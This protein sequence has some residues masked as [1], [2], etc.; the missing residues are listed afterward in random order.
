MNPPLLP[1]LDRS[2][3]LVGLMGAGKSSVGK[4][5]AQRL[6]LPFVDADAEIEAAA[7]CTIEA[8]FE[9]FGEAEFRAGERRIMA[10][11]LDDPVRVIAAGGGAYMDPDTRAA[12]REKGIAV[13]LQ[14]ELDVLVH[15]V[16]RRNNRPLLKQGDQRAILERLIQL[17]YPIYAEA[18]ITV[19]TSDQPHKEL[20]SIIVA[21]LEEQM[22]C[23]APRLSASAP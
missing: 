14:T 5:L 17:R 19:A 2:V 10:R 8:I 16:K 6:R 13:W 9:Q 12:I 20:V 23:R 7:G 21:R 11:L 22:A 15:R 4:R 1:A 3:V 18:D